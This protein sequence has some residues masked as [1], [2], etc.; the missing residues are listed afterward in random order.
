MTS[1][2]KMIQ[3]NLQ[4]KN[5]R[6]ALVRLSMSPFRCL[7]S[8]P[9]FSAHRTLRTPDL[10]TFPFESSAGVS[11]AESLTYPTSKHI[12]W[13]GIIRIEGLI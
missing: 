8:C 6:R 5:V 4:Y 10:P 9:S 13:I 2:E 7:T 1:L 12:A 11:P 3:L